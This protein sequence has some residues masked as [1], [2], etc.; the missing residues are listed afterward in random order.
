MMARMR[1]VVAVFGGNLEEPPVLELAAAVGVAVAESGALLLTGGRHDAGRSHVKDAAMAAAATVPTSRL[2]GVLPETG[3][4]TPVERIGRSGRAVYVR[5]GLGD[6][7]N[8]VNGY[9]CDGA[10]VLPGGPGTISEVLYSV[11][12]GR[13]VVQIGWDGKR[14]RQRLLRSRTALIA[15]LE[16]GTARFPTA[17]LPTIGEAEQ[18]VG[19]GTLET[20]RSPEDAIAHLADFA[21]EGRSREAVE[22]LESNG[23][24]ALGTQLAEIMA[25]LGV[26]GP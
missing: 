1:G 21:A 13:P 2:L 14:L 12:A 17:L 11:H 16:E 18:L 10:I 23:H 26:I 5:T 9:A 3:V 6:A 4:P 24:A 22:L 15:V 19:G 7:R 8:V 20:V 25:E